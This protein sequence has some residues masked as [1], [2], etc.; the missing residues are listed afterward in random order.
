MR[1][2]LDTNW[3]IDA[4][5]GGRR[6]VPVFERIEQIGSEDVGLSVISLAELSVGHYRSRD[7]ARS[8]AVTLG[9]IADFGLLPVDEETCEIFGRIKA[10]LQLAGNTIEDFDTMIAATAIQHDLTLLSNNR[11]HF[12]RVEGLTLDPA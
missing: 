5:R 9:F 12:N 10:Q 1:Y 2:L 11:N 7:G 4:I 3:A 8:R 6:A